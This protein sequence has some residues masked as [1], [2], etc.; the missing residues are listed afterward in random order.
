MADVSFSAAR[1]RSFWLVALY[2]HP[3]DTGAGRFGLSCRI[4]GAR[5]ALISDS[6]PQILT[7]APGDRAIVLR[8]RFTL[9]PR[10]RWAAGRYTVNCA[11]GSGTIF[12][13]GF[14][15]TR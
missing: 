9:A 4:T 2:D 12:S 1:V 8:A 6:G 14:D 3:T 13:T 5:N 11:G 10:Q 15:L 7:I